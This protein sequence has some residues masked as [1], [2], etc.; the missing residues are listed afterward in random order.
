MNAEP[1]PW[2]LLRQWRDDAMRRDVP[3]PA[4]TVLATASTSGVPSARVVLVK[5]ADENGFVF[6]TN[7]ESRKGAE[8]LANPC[9][10]LC[11]FWEETGRQLRVEGK[12]EQISDD[13]SDRYFQERARASRVGAW[14]SKQSQPIA[15]EGGLMR[16]L[17]ECEARF[18]GQDVPRPPHWGGFRLVPSVVEFWR[19][20]KFRL[21]ER[22][23]YTKEDE[24]WKREALYP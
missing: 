18:R 12:V 4:W 15:E 21:H 22:I 14:A 20:G 13:E 24:Q 17:E 23:R 11:Y 10:A 19:E 5:R 6:F 2:T 16:R 1:H 9:A 7:K 8:L 3:E